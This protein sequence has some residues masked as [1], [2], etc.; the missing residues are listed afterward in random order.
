MDPRHRSAIRRV[1][2]ERHAMGAGSYTRTA[3]VQNARIPA[4]HDASG[5]RIARPLLPD[6]PR[7]RTAFSVAEERAS[8]EPYEK[9]AE[10]AVHQTSPGR[11]GPGIAAGYRLNREP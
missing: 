11:I 4:G 8:L 2:V 9:V 1:V 10:T 7:D 5:L 6:R 3:S